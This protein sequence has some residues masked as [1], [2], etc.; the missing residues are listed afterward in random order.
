M[1]DK[2]K[3]WLWLQIGR[4]SSLQTM[5]NPPATR[6]QAEAYGRQAM[7]DDWLMSAPRPKNDA[8]DSAEKQKEGAN[9][10]REK[11]FKENGK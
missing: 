3:S 8:P 5:H 7:G 6:E 11:Y 4:T 1:T 10:Y 2:P 9:F